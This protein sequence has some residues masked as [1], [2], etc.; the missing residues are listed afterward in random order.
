V[1]SAKSDKQR[2]SLNTSV[3]SDQSLSFHTPEFNYFCSRTIIRIMS[4]KKASG[5]EL[6]VDIGGGVAQITFS[7]PA[8]NSLPGYLLE[9]LAEAILLAGENESARVVVVK[10]GGDRT[11]CAGASF[12]ELLSIADEESGRRFFSGFARVINAMRRCPKFVI[13]R[14]Q[15]KAVGGGVGLAA[16]ADYCLATRHAAIRLS[17]L[18]LGFGPFVIGPA[19][20]RKIGVAAMTRLA[21]DAANWQSAEWA[22]RQGLYAELFDSVAAL[23]E[24]VTQLCAQIAGYSPP[25]MRRLKETFWRGTE[26]WDELLTRRA[27][28]SA[29]LALSE[30]A[31]AAIRAAKKT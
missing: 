31:Q 4:T 5:G 2:A 18:A 9:E 16:A 23:D 17:E 6:S 28:I 7:H 20:E 13:C 8:H 25:A 15:G 14:V 22:Y 11:F 10:S 29:E 1:H 12:D 3:S 26:D 19:V 27:A 24:A 30:S 21:I